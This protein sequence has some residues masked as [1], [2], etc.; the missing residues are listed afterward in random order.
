RGDIRSFPGVRALAL[1]VE[2]DPDPADAAHHGGPEPAG[3][4]CGS[5][6]RERLRGQRQGG[7]RD[8]DHPA[9]PGEPERPDPA[10]SPPP[11]GAESAVRSAAAAAVEAAA[12]ITG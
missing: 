9:A 2:P 7:A 1:P 8:R 3:Q 11:R 4:A 6:S 5:A 10:D 12:R